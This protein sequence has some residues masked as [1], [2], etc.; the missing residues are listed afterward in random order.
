MGTYSPYWAYI[1]IMEKKMETTGII[2][3]KGI[4]WAYIGIMA[5]TSCYASTEPPTGLGTTS[6]CSQSPSGWH[7]GGADDKSVL[8]ASEHS[9]GTL[10]KSQLCQSWV[11]YLLRRASTRKDPYDIHMRPKR[12]VSINT[13]SVLKLTGSIWQAVTDA[14]AGIPPIAQAADIVPHMA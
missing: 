3:F 12:L 8:P 1:G 5:K 7:A 2:G 14:A 9:P 13:K 6:R 4:Y 11:S 10:L